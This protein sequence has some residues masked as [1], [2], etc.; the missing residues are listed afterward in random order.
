MA[1]DDDPLF[2]RNANSNALGKCTENIKT[3]VPEEVKNHLSGLA[4]L[5]NKT[6]SEYVRDVLLSH[7]YGHL[8]AVRLQH[9]FTGGRAGIGQESNR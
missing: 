6:L 3:L 8:H 1:N 7:V 9:G 2:S 4:V 5:H